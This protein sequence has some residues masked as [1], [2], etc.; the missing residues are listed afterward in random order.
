VRQFYIDQTANT[1]ARYG[2]E[3]SPYGEH[4][5]S[6][7]RGDAVAARKHMDLQDELM[8]TEGNNAGPTDENIK[9]VIKNLKETYLLSDFL[10]RLTEDARQLNKV[11]AEPKASPKLRGKT[12]DPEMD[13]L[14][15]L[16][17]DEESI[18]NGIQKL[19]QS[20]QSGK[21]MNVADALHPDSDQKTPQG[22]LEERANSESKRLQ[23]LEEEL[24]QQDGDHSHE[25]GKK[26]AATVRVPLPKLR[27]HL[28]G[29]IGAELDH[30]LKKF[31]T[32]RDAGATVDPVLK[33]KIEEYMSKITAHLLHTC[34]SY[35]LWDEPQAIADETKVAN[36]G[37][38]DELSKLHRGTHLS[39]S[40]VVKNF[41]TDALAP[42]RTAVV[43]EEW[44]VKKLISPGAFLPGVGK[45]MVT[46]SYP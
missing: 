42:K 13:E 46:T 16:Q 12:S 18:T 39:S 20:I 14:A 24:Q 2:Y 10:D 19:L 34:V 8:H 28:S 35:E 3:D 37:D 31:K 33:A 41:I 11:E 7:R 27:Q 4:D 5:V 1:L 21:A 22:S 43:P 26:P 40:K 38:P 15:A 30:T 36:S 25:H 44:S 29:F 23:Q 32:M 6:V 9:Q 45:L 17:S